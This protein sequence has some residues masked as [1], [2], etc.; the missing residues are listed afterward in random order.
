[1]VAQEREVIRHVPPGSLVLRLP[2]TTPLMPH[3]GIDPTSSL[4]RSRIAFEQAYRDW[5]PTSKATV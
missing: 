4:G 5:T 1:M 2:S 3:F